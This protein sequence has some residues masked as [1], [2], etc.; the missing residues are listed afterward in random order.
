M[1]HRTS[2]FAALGFSLSNLLDINNPQDLLRSLLNVM[3]FDQSKEDNERPKIVSISFF[4][5]LRAKNNRGAESLQEGPKEGRR[6]RNVG[7]C[8]V[9]IR[10]G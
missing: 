5:G 3:E 2:R 10:R 4:L 9:R 8:G 7:I 6:V 1:H